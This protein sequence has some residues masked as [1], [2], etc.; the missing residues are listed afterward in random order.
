MSP[1]GP[2]DLPCRTAGY[3][4]AGYYGVKTAPCQCSG[5]IVPAGCSLHQNRRHGL[6][7]KCGKALIQLPCG[8]ASI[9]S[10]QQS[11]RTK[12]SLQRC[13]SCDTQATPK[14]LQ[15]FR[16]FHGTPSRY[17]FSLPFCIPLFVRNLAVQVMKGKSR[18]GRPRAM[19]IIKCSSERGRVSRARAAPHP[20]PGPA[21]VEQP[22]R[23]RP[24]WVSQLHH[25]YDARKSIVWGGRDD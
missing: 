24:I 3:Q 10:P 18:G 6:P 25:Q 7:H 23:Y 11:M 15:V 14:Q 4:P 17:P 22:H 19:G 16:R 1:F 5:R 9:G 13:T 8:S 12:V 21:P 2:R 20:R